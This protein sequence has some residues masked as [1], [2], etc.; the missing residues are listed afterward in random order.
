MCLSS[1]AAMKAGQSSKQM[2]SRSSG[3]R[4]DPSRAVSSIGLPRKELTTNKPAERDCF[5]TYSTSFALNP[6]L[7]GDQNQSGQ[8]G[9]EF[10]HDPFGQIVR[11]YRN[12]LAGPEARE[13]SARG[14]RDLPD[15]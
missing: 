12:P 15:R 1:P 9:T 13:Q 11:P 6:G 10:E 3:H 4:G 5:S 7:T 8:A 2:I 14:N